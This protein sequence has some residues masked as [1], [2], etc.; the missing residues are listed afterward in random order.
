M[1]KKP[2]HRKEPR[3]QPPPQH[4]SKPEIG[5]LW[6]H[7]QGPNVLRVDSDTM[8]MRWTKASNDWE[9]VSL[10]LYRF[11]GLPWRQI[12][13]TT[14]VEI[15]G[16]KSWA[17]L[18]PLPLS[19]RENFPHWWAFKGNNHIVR[20]DRE[21]VVNGGKVGWA[22]FKPSDPEEVTGWNLGAYEVNSP[23]IRR[24][25]PDEA[26]KIITSSRPNDWKN[27]PP[28]VRTVPVPIPPPPE[29]GDT[30]PRDT[31]QAPL[32]SNQSKSL[33]DDLHIVVRWFESMAKRGM[34]TA[35]DLDVLML[36]LIGAL[37]RLGK[38]DADLRNAE[39]EESGRVLADKVGS[40]AA[41][42]MAREID[43]EFLNVVPGPY[44]YEWTGPDGGWR[45]SDKADN[46]IATC[47]DE[48]HAKL[49]VRVLNER[50]AIANLCEL[51]N[52]LL[53]LG[54]SRNGDEWQGNA[55]RWRAKYDAMLKKCQSSP[56]PS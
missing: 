38:L 12:N 1:A 43:A 30:E 28:S 33:H 4:E 23:S 54:V 55:A 9:S 31:T 47:W 40:I 14:A 29:P 56:K 2:K 15:V 37:N 19:E 3:V 53:K 46:R 36:M 22:W 51:A 13:N 42:A 21:P 35:L 49:I 18:P 16:P 50:D 52:D 32:L 34:P 5:S 24:I 27:Q 11:P 20:V 25:S 45:I 48:D 7:S 44:G 10:G 41:N 39:L 26:E 6:R 17:K 8:G